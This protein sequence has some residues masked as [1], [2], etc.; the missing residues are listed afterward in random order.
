MGE[1]F[2]NFFSEHDIFEVISR[3]KEM[4]E[5]KK[6]F[7][8]D[9]CEFEDIIEFYIEHENST[10]ALEAVKIAI[11]RYPFASSL[12]LKYAKIL[13]EKGLT[14]KAM[15]V[16]S[17]IEGVEKFNYEFHLVKGYSLAKLGNHNEAYQAFDRAIKL[18][19]ENRDE[20]AY[21]IAISFIDSGKEN[22]ALKYLLL[23]HELNENNLLVLCELASYSENIEQWE[24]VVKYYKKFLDID[25][26]AE[27]IWYGLGYAYSRMDK[28]DKAVE[29][30]DFALAINPRYYSAI[31]TKGEILTENGDY[32]RAIDLY[33]ELVDTE[34]DNLQAICCLGECYNQKGEYTIAKSYLNRAKRIDSS[35]ACVWYG[36]AMIY[37]NLKKHKSC[38]SNLNKAIKLDKTNADYWFSLGLTYEELKQQE[39][40]QKAFEQAT[41]LDPLK[42]EAWLSFADIMYK[43]NKTNDAIEILQKA[44]LFNYD[45]ATI[46][47]K[48]ATYYSINQQ[49]NLAKEYFEKGLI[50][51]FNEHSEFLALILLKFDHPEEIF[52]LLNKYHK[53]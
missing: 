49:F 36:I 11:K 23:A 6:S 24:D 21:D 14:G 25:P 37:K 19:C 27:N 34:N 41:A 29:A 39:K 26:F 40:A 13:D 32:D 42:T 48:L 17:E 53:N 38:I 35:N 4:M 7:F 12:K 20:V 15:Q 43:N 47:Y 31:F 30:F 9:L 16:I 22:I 2:D 8:F 28:N 18:S 33:N 51:N 3:Y 44:Y 5:G 10:R 46:N 50:L 1:E 52:L 45:V